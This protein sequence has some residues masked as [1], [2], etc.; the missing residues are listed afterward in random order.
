MS[1]VDNAVEQMIEAILNSGEYLHYREELMKVKQVPELK[2]RL[3]EFRKRRFLLQ[4]S[5]D[6]AFD[7][8]EEFEKEFQEFREEP[9]VEAFLAAE[10]SFC[11]MMQ[12]VDE[13]ITE[14]LQ[15]E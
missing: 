2:A 5:D 11:R 4:H 7:K 3:D 13:R 15:F 9:Q 1:N 10:L 14:A 12:S 6:Y 8:L